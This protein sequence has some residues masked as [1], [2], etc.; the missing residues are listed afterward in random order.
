[1]IKEVG[2]KKEMSLNKIIELINL[3]GEKDDFSERASDKQISKIEQ[4]LDVILPNSYQWFL[5]HFGH[6]GIAGVEI[7]GTTA[8]GVYPV[9]N[10]TIYC[11]RYNLPPSFVLIEN[12]DEWVNC[13]DTARMNNGEC[14]VVS[15]DRFGNSR[16]K[17]DNFYDFLFDQ[18]RQAVDN[19][20]EEGLV[21]KNDR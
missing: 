7:L 20:D 21:L 17:Y 1:M 16:I 6:G 14:P 3:Y 9:I 13:L 11:R 5:K 2:G 4:D 10:A 8:M 18:F 15:W 12:V 19:L